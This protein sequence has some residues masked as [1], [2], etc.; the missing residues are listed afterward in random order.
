MK[1]EAWMWEQPTMPWDKLVFIDETG[2]N[3]GMTRLYGRASSHQ[4]VVDYTPD[5]R[6]ERTTVLS[7]IRASAEMVPL[8]FEGALDGELFG[9]Y[10]A[11]CLAPSL[12]PG[13]IVIMDNLSSH[14]VEGVIEP[15]I[16]AGATV[17]YLPPYSPDLNPIELMWSKIKTYLRKLKARTKE[18]LE[19]A[20]AEALGHIK[21][22]DVLAWFEK[23]GYS[24][25]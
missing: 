25:Q 19:Q 6:F 21:Q 3:T 22:T 14:K 23:F 12:K 4:R 1:R 18:T 2:I 10:V 24:T 5:I 9:K 15:I 17:R 16:A 11:Q 8:I 7:S 13:D 20:L